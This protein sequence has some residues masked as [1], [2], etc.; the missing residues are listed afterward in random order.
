MPISLQGISINLK[1]IYGVKNL[2]LF[3]CETQFTFP[4][5]IYQKSNYFSPLGTFIKLRKI[6]W[7]LY[8]K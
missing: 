2:D 6:P 3:L 1:R 8:L 7:D 5:E 4:W